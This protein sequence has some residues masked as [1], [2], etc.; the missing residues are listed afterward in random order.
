[1]GLDRWHEHA[2]AYEQ[3]GS[4][5][6]FTITG[7][8]RLVVGKLMDGESVHKWDMHMSIFEVA[9]SNTYGRLT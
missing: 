2:F 7:L 1:M 4:G 8:E 3:A 6:T 5:K 9:G